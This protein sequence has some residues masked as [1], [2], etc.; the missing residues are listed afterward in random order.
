MP[1]VGGVAIDLEHGLVGLKH[2]MDLKV[3]H[4]G[5]VAGRA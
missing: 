2:H 1:R 5:R 4:S 3:A